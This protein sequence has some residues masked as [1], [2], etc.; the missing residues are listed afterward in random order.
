VRW[1]GTC[2]S[3]KS[4]SPDQVRAQ[5]QWFEGSASFENHE[6]GTLALGVGVVTDD[7][8]V[9]VGVSAVASLELT[10]NNVEVFSP[11]KG[12]FQYDQ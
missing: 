11:K 8:H 5:N 7:A 12:S 9:V 2:P 3:G 4:W 10:H 6:A 1:K